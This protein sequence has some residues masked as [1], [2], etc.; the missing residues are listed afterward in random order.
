[1]CKQAYRYKVEYQT[2]RYFGNTELRFIAYDSDV[3][4]MMLFQ[5]GLDVETVGRITI[6]PGAPIPRICPLPTELFTHEWAEFKND[7]FKTWTY[8]DEDEIEIIS[9]YLIM[10][11]EPEG[12]VRMRPWVPFNALNLLENP[13][14]RKSFITAN[15]S[16]IWR[17]RY[18][19]LSVVIQNFGS[20]ALTRG[21]AEMDDVGVHSGVLNAGALRTIESPNVGPSAPRSEE[22]RAFLASL[23][24]VLTPLFNV[25]LRHREHDPLL[26]VPT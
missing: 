20:E 21:S 1:V 19:L 8:V 14:S 4:A 10:M 18:H 15:A 26:M 2:P 6:I 23:E 12:V 16:W 11:N 5:Y 25:N 22:C 3:G 24:R 7:E 17:H 9:T 13:Y